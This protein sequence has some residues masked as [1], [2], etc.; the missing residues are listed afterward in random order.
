MVN[1]YNFLEKAAHTNF[2]LEIWYGLEINMV[3][4]EVT[5][6]KLINAGSRKLLLPSLIGQFILLYT[7]FRCSQSKIIL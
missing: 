5:Y 4:I 6:Y 1:H 2:K 7:H 3:H